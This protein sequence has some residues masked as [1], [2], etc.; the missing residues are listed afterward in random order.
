MTYCGVTPVVI[1]QGLCLPR[2]VG[3]KDEVQQSDYSI[4][5]HGAK[6]AG[7]PR[8]LLAFEV[9]QFRWLWSSMF[10][11][12][13]SMGVRMLTQ[14]WL[15]LEIT[16]SPFWV[17]L[18][19][20]LQGLGQVGF[21]A[22]GGTIV[23][24]FDKRKVLATVY[25]GSGSL[26]ILIGVLV[27]TGHIALW[28]MLVVA[29]I[30][31]LLMAT[32]I[33]ASNS[34]GYQLVG[35]QRLL[36]A[37]AARQAGMNITRVIGS[38]IAGALISQYGV[39]SS[40]L[41]AGASSLVGVGFLWFIK[42]SFPAPNERE[43]FWHAVGQ[44]LKYAWGA[45]NIRRLLLLSLF[46]EAFGFS[47]FVMMPVMARDVL[48]VGPAGLGYLSAASGVGSTLSTIV[49]AGLG[50]FKSKGVLLT[51]TAIGAGISL[52]LFA[53]SPWFA[54]SLV[55]MGLVGASLMA[56]NVTMGT[57]LQLLCY[58]AMR[59][60]VLGIYGL[61]FGFTPIGGFLAGLVATAL[62]ASIAVAMGGIIIM[63]YVAGNVR[64]VIRISART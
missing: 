44:G 3:E 8:L 64:S 62:S 54:A 11:S 28:H 39:G 51:G 1:E 55:L 20:G 2:D 58:D 52:V 25:F 48:H 40:Y 42:G 49:V 6:Q 12:S 22:L 16:D 24:R 33:P 34:L 18:V 7:L 61:T 38:L 35:P 43:P 31:G 59:G 30:Q 27:V 21:G 4:T 19:A 45:I 46:M 47:H 60:R 57:T 29:L 32:Q 26:A 37:M 9:V 63:V 17:G 56:Y 36:N 5:A 15:V 41:F 23:D 53:F 14:G 50:D 13:M 10:F